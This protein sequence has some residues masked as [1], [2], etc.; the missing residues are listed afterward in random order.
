[1]QIFNLNKV[2]RLSALI[3]K[4]LKEAVSKK[5]ELI[6]SVLEAEEY[7]L[8]AGG[9]RIRPLLCLLF[10]EA[11]GKSAE[12]YA[13]VASSVEMIHTFSL[14]HDDMPCMDDDD[15]RRGVPS[16]HKKYGEAVALLA[17]DALSLL[18][19]ETLAS[20][21][22]KGVISAECCVEITG[23]LSSAAGSMGMIGG[24]IIDLGSEGKSIDI[25]TLR[26]LQDKK[27]GA[28]IKASCVMG[29]LLAGSKE[30]IPAAEEYAESLGLAFQI[31][32]DILDVE[33]SFEQLGKPIG[34]DEQQNKTTFVSVYGLENAKEAAGALTR[35]AA[36][37]ASK[38]KSPEL[39]TELAYE[40][41]HRKN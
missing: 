8:L 9:K 12:Q 20:E 5:P 6:K 39:L 18:A 37:S 27:T 1:M 33:G 34:S 15:F 35:N 29:C 7:S 26:E 24:Q 13:A 11:C 36:E 38:L 21:A 19:F 17:G 14:I 31:V 10:C 4:S 28:L 32:D 25:D 23:F 2:K 16:C 41:L 22:K 30:S 40:L 3:E